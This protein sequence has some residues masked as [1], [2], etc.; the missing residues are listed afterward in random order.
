MHLLAARSPADG[1]VAVSSSDVFVPTLL[2]LAIIAL[3]IGVIAVIR[4]LLLKSDDV[5]DDPMVGFSLGSL[6]Q[7][8]K[9]GK[10]TQ[11]E[12]E[13]AKARLVQAAQKQVDREN[14]TPAAPAAAEHKLPP[15]AGL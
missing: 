12:Y 10:M 6:R 8:V 7:L 11:E 15:D 13:K 9:E 14:P 1:V 2:L 4:R 5:T 3:L